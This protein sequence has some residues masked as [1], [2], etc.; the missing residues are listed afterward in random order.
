[1]AAPKRVEFIVTARDLT[2]RVFSRIGRS[3]ATLGA[4]LAA[5]ASA[6]AI[7]AA[8]VNA[9]RSA[10]EIQTMARA[11]NLTTTEF[12]ALQQFMAQFGVDADDVSDAL[13]SIS[14]AR[15]E[16]LRGDLAQEDAFRRLGIDPAVLRGRDSPLDF[17]LMLANAAEQAGD[18]VGNLQESFSR[19]LGEDNARRM[20]AALRQGPT[21]V[22]Q[23]MLQAVE[24]GRVA[25]AADIEA[26]NRAYV[27]GVNT[28]AEAN[29]LAIRGV[30][31][32]TTE[33]E[34]A[35]DRIAQVNQPGALAAGSQIEI[36]T[37]GGGTFSP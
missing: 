13:F 12:Q 35:A 6:G 21:A 33:L 7:A 3:L 34:A 9:A 5:F 25:A 2:R 11:V 23:G 27:T 8:G 30:S 29:V 14:Q 32:L 28:L 20:M 22:A 17:F 4:Q 16:A 18:N 24:S 15:S 37:I 36:Q 19:I 31:R 10:R 26:A 1:M